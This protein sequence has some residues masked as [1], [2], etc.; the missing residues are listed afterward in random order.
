MIV[1]RVI[2]DQILVVVGDLGECRHSW[3]EAVG[4]LAFDLVDHADLAQHLQIDQNPVEYLI[5][6]LEPERPSF[7]KV[8]AG[9]FP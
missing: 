9:L 6:I 4:R 8:Q 1:G 3:E 5:L 2:L 7:A